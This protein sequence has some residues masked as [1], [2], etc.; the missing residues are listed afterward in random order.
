MSNELITYYEKYKD[1]MGELAYCME[2]FK[3]T[4]RVRFLIRWIV[5]Y[6][7]PGARILD[8]GCGDMYLSTQLPD[9]DWVG[10]DI[11][12]NQSNDKAI[13]HDLMTTPYPFEAHSFDAVVCSEVLEHLWDPRV[14][15]REVKRLLKP[16]GYY[17]MSTPNYDYIDHYMFQFKQLLFDPDKS[18]LFEHIRQYNFEVHE[19]MLKE[20]GM[21]VEKTVGADAHF[22]IIFSTA[23]RNLHEVLNKQI[24][25]QI[26]EVGC[27]MILGLMFPYL[28]HTVM[29][30]ARSNE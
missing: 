21:R 24:G 28:N 29:I 18:W 15:Q 13:K 23:A 11:A 26:D 9:Y 12:P 3:D 10:V 14:V 22:S 7:K 5:D 1:T 16:D 17:F 8:I 4:S 30:V 20:A 19:R 25:V 6:L 2:K 27:Q